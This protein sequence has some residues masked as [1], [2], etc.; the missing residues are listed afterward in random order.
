[1]EKIEASATKGSAW[2]A[3]AAA[4]PASAVQAAAATRAERGKQVIEISGI[5]RTARGDN[6]S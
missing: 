5:G 2:A 6:S 3:G 1:M 4:K